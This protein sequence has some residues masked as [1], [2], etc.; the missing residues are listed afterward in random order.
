MYAVQVSECRIW[1]STHCCPEICSEYSVNFNECSANYT[2]V[3][4]ESA[5]CMHRV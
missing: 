5:L 4:G 1:P 3:G 2:N